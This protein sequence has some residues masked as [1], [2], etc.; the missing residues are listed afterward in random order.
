M[1]QKA[2]MVGKGLVYMVLITYAAISLYPLI[3]L[4]LYSFKNNEEIFVTNPFG[5]PRVWRGSN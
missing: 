2:R 3:W 1:K 5:L 4:L